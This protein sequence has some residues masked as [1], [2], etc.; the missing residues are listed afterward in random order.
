MAMFKPDYDAGTQFESLP[1]SFTAS[2][3]GSVGTAP[4][5]A[6]PE[7][8][9]PD[10]GP[11][12]PSFGLALDYDGLPPSSFLE[13]T[14]PSLDDY[15]YFSQDGKPFPLAQSILPPQGDV[16]YASYDNNTQDYLYPGSLHPNNASQYDNGQYTFDPPWAWQMTGNIN[17]FQRQAPPIAAAPPMGVSPPTHHPARRPNPRQSQDNASIL[18][19]V[20]RKPRAANKSKVS[21]TSP[22]NK[23]GVIARIIHKTPFVCEV[24]GCMNKVG[25]RRKE[26]LK[27]HHNT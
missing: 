6:Y 5:N 12:T 14:V 11:S 7:P 13:N 25:F 4:E 3:Q 1:L 10:S 9:T 20:Q 27:R 26:H 24:A 2:S 19:R 23:N 16:P 22:T 17:M 8:Y 18:H 15:N 21:Q